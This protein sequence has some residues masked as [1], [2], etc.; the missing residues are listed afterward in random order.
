ML[1]TG[2]TG[3]CLSKRKRVKRVLND[4][5]NVVSWK[6]GGLCYTLEIAMA[7]G[8]VQFIAKV[9]ITRWQLATNNVSGVVRLVR[10]SLREALSLSLGG[11]GG[12]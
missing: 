1:K 9:Y 4:S 10:S 3:G 7:A 11:L 6:E 5:M 2:L 12:G 8:S